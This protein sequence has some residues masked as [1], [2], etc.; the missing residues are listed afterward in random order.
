MTK[1]GAKQPLVRVLFNT[2]W[3]L[4][5]LVLPALA[6]LVAF[7]YLTH[8]L[9]LERM[10]LLTLGWVVIGYFSLFDFGIARSLTKLVAERRA[11]QG[12]A[13]VRPLASSG[14]VVA[15][16]FGLVGAGVIAALAPWLLAHGQHNAPAQTLAWA[17]EVRR[18]IFWIALGTPLVVWSAALRGVLEG[19]ESF[20][21]LALIRGPTGAAVFLLPCM[22]TWGWPTLDAAI[23]ASLAARVVA[24]VAML[25]AA[26]PWIRWDAHHVTWGT[27]KAICLY[28]GWISV[29]SVLGPIIT[30]ADRFVLGAL[31]SASLVAFYTTPF[32]MVSRLLVVPIALTSSL[33]PALSALRN[34][35][36]AEARRTT[37]RAAWIN[38]GVVVA[39]AVPLALFAAWW[40]ERWMGADFARQSAQVSM[41]LVLAF[42]L[43]ALAHVPTT[44][45]ISHDGARQVALW[46]LAQ[47]PLY[48]ALL[49]W[50]V[51]HHGL[52]GAAWATTFRSLVD[53]LALAWM[54]RRLDAQ[55][56]ARAMAASTSR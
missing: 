18:A 13:A 1:P 45:I 4:S 11:L 35:N 56:W 7:P 26:R 48:V 51:G 25:V 3:N 9:G 44:N 39:L 14:L 52:L 37:S 2:G 55:A 6:A 8:R 22:V 33:L 41:W 31:A 16:L 38:A 32:E 15:G 34:V 46:N 47:L 24:M 10:G 17:E 28:G 27:M 29:A 23:L 43:N 50:C 53:W 30:H 36:E 19:L 49:V 54:S 5:S 42:A 21:L 40:L 12:D 20:R